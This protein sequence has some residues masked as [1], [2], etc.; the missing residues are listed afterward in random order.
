MKKLLTLIS[1]LA[2]V[3]FISVAA[4]LSVS[5]VES[6]KSASSTALS[7]SGDESSSQGDGVSVWTIA[8]SS[9]SIF[10]TA[11]DPSNTS[12]DMIL[13][14][15]GVYVLEK[16]GV[17]L[18]R[19]ASYEFKVV[20]NHSWDVNYGADGEAGGSNI[21]FSVDQ[22]GVYNLW[23][24]FYPDNG[25]QLEY[26]YEYVSGSSIPM[27][28]IYSIDYCDYGAFPFYVMGYVP[29]FYDCMMT[30]YGAMYKYVT[31]DNEAGET[32]DYIVKTAS[33]VEYYRIPLESPVWHQYFI[34]DRIP[35]IEGGDYVV[36]AQVRA[37]EP[38]TFN[39]NM[40][41]GWSEGQ[42][43]SATVAIG[44][45]WQEVEW[46]YSNI[47]GTSC[48]L[49]AQPGTTTATIYWNKVQVYNKPS[50][51]MVQE[52]IN[53]DSYSGVYFDGSQAIAGQYTNVLF[54]Q[55]QGSSKPYG[56][57]SNI[58]F[59]PGNTMTL[60]SDLDIVKVE[61]NT[62]YWM[63]SYIV[64]SGTISDN[65]WRGN[66][67]EL[68][69]TSPTDESYNRFYSI[70]V[71]L[72]DPSQ[73]ALLERL[74]AQL[75]ATTTALAGLTYAVPGKAEL[76]TLATEAATATLETEAAQLK[77]YI[78]QLREQTAAVV[79]LDGKY[80]TL[81]TLAAAVA[82][83]AESNPYADATILAEASAL[84]QEVEAG[85][86]A[87]TYTAAQVDPL[88]A[89]LTTYNQQLADVYLT[90]H[91]EEAGSLGDLVL[92][93]G[94]DFGDVVGL[95]V[96]GKLNT[97][98]QTTLKGFNKLQL[99]DLAETNLTKITDQQF[100]GKSTLKKV[101]LPNKTTTI[102]SYAFQNC[103][104]LEEVVVPETLQTIGYDAFY[105]C[106]A[107]TSFYFPE[108]LTRIE[109]SAFYCN[110][111]SYYDEY[112][113]YVYVYGGS[114]REI[115][116]PGTLVD[117]MNMTSAIGSEAFSN[118]RQL[119]K[120]TL[121]E[122][123]TSLPSNVFSNCQS[124]TDLTLP[125]TLKSIGSYAF[126][127]CS[128]LKTLDLP[129]GLT[130]IS[131]YAFDNCSALEEV[132]LPST[133][134]SLY[135]PFYSCPNLTK[136]TVKAI[137]A[138]DPQGYSIMGNSS[139]AANVTL[140]VPN[141]SINVYKQA[142][143]WN[144]FNIVG[145]DI[146]PE[147][148]TI[149]TDYRLNW[150]EGLALDYRPNI[151]VASNASLFV[152]GNSVLS[153]GNFTLAYSYYNA[154]NNSQWNSELQRYCYNRDN[155]FAALLNKATYARANQVN[156]EAYTPT[157][158]WS[159]MSMPFDVKA[160]DIA[161]MFDETPYVIRKYDGTKRAEGK[162]GET[163]VNI[164]AEETI[165]AGQGFILQSA[166]TDDKRYYNGFT[167]T[168]VNNEKKNNIFANDDVDVALAEYGA[169]FE[170]NRSWNL[171]G[172]PYPA[173]YDIRAMQ[174]SAPIT[175]WD[176]YNNN[177][178][179]YSPVDDAYILNPGQAFFIQRPIN[180][181]ETLTFKKEGRQIDMEVRPLED[182][183]NRAPRVDE[184]S[185]FNLTVNGNEMSDRTRF[186]INNS[187]KMEYEAGRDAN[188]FMSDEQS[189]QLY[190]IENGVQ[191]AINERPLDNAVIELGLMVSKT[192]SYTITLNTTVDNE[193][194][195]IDR[196]TGMEV[197][198]DG[199]EGGYTFDVEQG[200]IEGRFAIRL[201]LGDVTGIKSIERD[202][203]NGE[204][205]YDLQGRKID[206]PAK[207][208]YINNGKKV[209]VQ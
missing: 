69:I 90:I 144:E 80:K 136:M 134:Q 26:S 197:R 94:V 184:R 63:G 123:I 104:A 8:G 21:G 96:S 47:G 200:T 198:I 156:V 172:N 52:T 1:M 100:S 92:E 3:A 205:Y 131:S 27:E 91:V 183:A 171:I 202:F 19:G 14:K 117:E 132:I 39:I 186:V 107:L 16:K 204:N 163:W 56:K 29:E 95:R 124:L 174:T 133:L 48:N 79:A 73:E 40:G 120:V 168:A 34:A 74:T 99:I 24:Y 55:G 46:E 51:S 126:S 209:V 157:N 109:S 2:V 82:T 88:I 192:G 206:Q 105:N 87:C 135:R 77:A 112:G 173:Y 97:A 35:T 185:V 32:S 139:D 164:G 191:F 37:S 106:R 162:T 58:Y 138:P 28:C 170:H 23:F 180:D 148:I 22:S 196:L 10:G 84:V 118:Q 158:R 155:C 30:D 101:V 193:V 4:T 121:A 54:A 190:T 45:E 182:V 71:T 114:L 13:E 119:T 42:Q 5:N 15:E 165:P 6:A 20:G 25:H 137:A 11:W 65:T 68:T 166:S 50:E 169:E 208:I 150:P 33:G 201:G 93:K 141:L 9:E 140:T 179:A 122:G 195:L 43:A 143:Y 189:I 181:G 103:Y 113:N 175:I 159:F 160:S 17:Q 199:I 115:S 89:T 203:N 178:Q 18:E 110:N 108:G 151:Y 44:T 62:Y 167:F 85:L 125:S 129:E 149:N 161:L 187:A 153:A 176:D 41:W 177:Y 61:F 72:D 145:A 70:T 49:V 146:M 142:Q 81:A 128:A 86:L 127:Y 154:T 57:G 66:T 67:S 12:N 7:A 64:S 75:E 83:T 102:G 31:L 98:D 78:K 194:Y 188:K 36:R 53:F 59:N 38:V 76:E 147:N 116:L 60:T 130:S 152:N 207:G 111:S